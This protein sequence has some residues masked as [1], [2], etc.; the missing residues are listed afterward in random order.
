MK[1]I[2]KQLSLIA[3][4][5]IFLFHSCQNKSEEN[6]SALKKNITTTISIEKNSFDFGTIKQNDSV[7]FDFSFKNTGDKPLIIR[8]VQASCGC[9]VPKWD[10]NPVKPG[11]TTK[12]QVV[13]KP[14]ITDIGIIKKSIA[15]NVNTDSIIHILYMNGNVSKI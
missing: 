9:T 3:M 10:A 8:S 14:K 7:K 4:L 13:Y 12:I 6:A 5:S 2:H 1:L 11:A 15:V